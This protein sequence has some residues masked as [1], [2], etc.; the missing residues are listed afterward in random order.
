MILST[1]TTDG[2]E[3][4]LNTLRSL[5]QELKSRTSEV[6]FDKDKV[7]YAIIINAYQHYFLSLTG[8]EIID[9]ERAPKEFER[10]LMA[11]QKLLELLAVDFPA[12]APKMD[13]GIHLLKQMQID[14]KGKSFDELDRLALLKEHLIPFQDLLL[15]L[16]EQPEAIELENN[17][18]SFETS[19][20]F[21]EHWLNRT[22]FSKLPPALQ[23]EQAI[24]LG[25]LLFYEPMLSKN[26]KRTCASCHKAQKA[27]S[28]G[29]RTSLAFD[30]SSNLEQN[31]PALLNTIY[32]KKYGHDLRF[33]SLEEQI[34]FVVNNHQEFR[35]SFKEIKIK[36]ST[37][38]SYK[39]LFQEVFGEHTEIDSVSITGAL[40][41]YLATLTSFNSPFDQF[42]RGDSAKIDT[43]VAKGYN[44]FMGKAQC[45]SC[46]FAPL[47]SGLK[48]MSYTEQGAYSMY[49]NSF[50]QLAGTKPEPTISKSEEKKYKT[51]TIRN[52]KYTIPY[53]HDGS[54]LELDSFLTWKKPL[55]ETS[56]RYIQYKTIN[57]KEKHAL[58]AFL[59]SLNDATQFIPPLDLPNTDGTLA[60]VS[61]R[62][63]GIY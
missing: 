27:F 38:E 17:P 63:A 13:L 21:S 41:A 49:Q 42:M 60:P 23:G 5:L 54:I 33:S 51:P 40:K 10:I 20:P 19:N 44:L 56:L 3:E 8:H 22:Y 43:L 36:L 28:D 6:Y 53:G 52:L 46:H 32:N 30:F 25:K 1:D 48:P 34:E 14:I 26:N 35:S 12:D 15:S 31:A 45:G 2:A 47:F 18:L 50:H 55:Q 59:A 11:Y 16:I 57:P 4:A 39:Q 29:R 58:K 62:P 37:S 9:V 7:L 24:A 61:R